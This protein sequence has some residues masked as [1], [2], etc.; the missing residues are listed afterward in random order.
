MKTA[1]FPSSILL[2]RKYAAQLDMPDFELGIRPH[3]GESNAR[4]DKLA[5]VAGIIQD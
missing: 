2:V 1:R 3:S 4:S 5:V